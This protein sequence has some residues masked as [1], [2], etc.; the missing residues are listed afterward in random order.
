M[1]LEIS[2]ILATIVIYIAIVWFIGYMAHKATKK[3][4]VVSYVV[5][6]RKLSPFVTLMTYS[7]TFFSA[8]MMIGYAGYTYANGIAGTFG[9]E[10]F[11]T[12]FTGSLLIIYVGYKFWSAAQARGYIS[13]S[14]L[15]RDSYGSTWVAIV[16]TLL[17]IMWIVPHSM[18][19]Y[20]G[21]AKLLDGLTGGVIPYLWG[22]ALF[23]VVAF[24]YTVA[25]GVR[26]VA[27]TDVVQGTIMIVVAFLVMGFVINALGGFSG[28][29]NAVQTQAPAHLTFPGPSNLYTVVGYLSI[30]IPFVFQ[31]LCNPQANQ[32]FFMTNKRGIK[33]TAFGFA[34]FSFLYALPITIF[35]VGGKVLFPNLS[36]AD[37]ITPTILTSIVPPIVALIAMTGVWS[38]ALSTID[39]QMLTLSSMFSRD[40]L[41]NAAHPKITA[42]GEILS[43]R[44]FM[45]IYIL[46]V[47][48][49]SMTPVPF[50]LTLGILSAAGVSTLAPTLLGSVL[51]KR[52]T[53]AGAL[54]SMIVGSAVLLTL[55]LTNTKLLG[56]APGVWGVI[57]SFVLYFVVSLATKPRPESTEIHKQKTKG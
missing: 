41:K 28:Y 4:D 11:V 39:S 25:G 16:A 22:I 12:V 54:S 43:I 19:Q 24:V 34:I 38:A 17:G 1:A 20:Q 33:Y 50:I 53:A 23:A 14:E 42:K 37:S 21:I 45:V 31:P 35:A 47:F 48:F 7:A 15:L 13:S 5:A 44:I 9:F 29:V 52:G 10:M 2:W 40:I 27:W 57:V 55:Q 30:I 8:Y 26:A 32:R 18:M 36:A 49:F 46:I 3:D 56:W 51:W 6:D